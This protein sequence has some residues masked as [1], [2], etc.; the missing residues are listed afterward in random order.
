MRKIIERCPS[1][2]QPDMMITNLRCTE[3]D[4]EVRGAFVASRFCRLSDPSLQFLETFVR[5]RG[6]LKEM[7]RELN[8]AYATLR[9]RLN[10]V[11]QEMGYDGE[12]GA[13]EQDEEERAE[14]RTARLQ[15]LSSLKEGQIDAEKAIEA[16]KEL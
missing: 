1:C 16:L 9:S 13:D 6:N 3:C 7:E 14:Q 12:T 15:V 11:I 8:I 5:N 2:G 4:T 10:Q